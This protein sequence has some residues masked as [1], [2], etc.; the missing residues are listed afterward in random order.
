MQPIFL[1]DFLAG[2]P[3]VAVCK[4]IDHPLVRQLRSFRL[5]QANLQICQAALQQVPL[6]EPP[7]DQALW[8]AALNLYLMA[9]GSGR[10]VVMLDRQKVLSP[11]QISMFHQLEKSRGRE[12]EQ[13]YGDT[14][15]LLLLDD[16]QHLIS[17]ASGIKQTQPLTLVPQLSELVSQSLGWVEA[18][19]H[20]L[21]NQLA[22]LYHQW[23]PE[24]L[25]SLPDWCN[26]G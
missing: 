18:K 24:E 7:L 4:S 16:Q 25:A 12:L 23:T 9:F 6:V 10:G 22:D 8:M 3:R 21:E 20:A 1:K 11:E 14:V 26:Q 5:H 17:V 15:A 13:G 2:H 19:C